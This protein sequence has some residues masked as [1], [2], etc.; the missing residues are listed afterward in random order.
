MAELEITA[1]R[2]SELAASL[3]GGDGSNLLAGPFDMDAIAGKFSQPVVHEPQLVLRCGVDESQPLTLA[4][5]TEVVA[6]FLAGARQCELVGPEASLDCMVS[7]GALSVVRLSP[8]RLYAVSAGILSLMADMAAERDS[9]ALS[10]ESPG[11]PNKPGPV[12][13][14]GE[15]E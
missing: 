2:Y 14:K 11:E 1:H 7:Q 10:A 5:A 12:G 15:F 8:A 3:D 4:T 6:S 13:P 9:G